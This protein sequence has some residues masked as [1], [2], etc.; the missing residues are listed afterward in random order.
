M[1][2][3]FFDDVNNAGFF[4]HFYSIILKV[5]IHQKFKKSLPINNRSHKSHSNKIHHNNNKIMMISFMIISNR[6]KKMNSVKINVIIF[7][8]KSMNL[9]LEYNNVMD[10]S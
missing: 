4:N 9:F 8:R 3:D 10:S 2:D 6:N 5:A 7:I 1:E